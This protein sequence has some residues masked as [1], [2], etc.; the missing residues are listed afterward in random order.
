MI[1]KIF[2]ACLQLLIAAVSVESRSPN[3]VILLADDQGWG[4]CLD[5]VAGGFKRRTWTDCFAN[6]W[7]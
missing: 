6:L 1:R 7:N 5:T 2:C 3:V 4:T